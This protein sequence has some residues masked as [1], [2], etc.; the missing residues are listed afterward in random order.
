VA[1]LGFG[2]SRWNAERIRG[3]TECFQE[4]GLGVD[5]YDAHAPSAQAGEHACSAILLGPKRPQA[6]ICYNDLIALGF[7]KEARA[8]GFTLPDDVSV[9]GFDNVPYGE[10]ASPAL[11]TMDLQSERMGEVAM[12]KLLDLLA[13]HDGD[14]EYSLLEPRLIVR[15]STQRREA[16]AQAAP[17]PRRKA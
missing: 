15:E 4:A 13:G 16:G 14:G 8:L 3:V 1:Y 12:Q 7:M 2:Q 11:T 5:I 9:V 17:K 10:Y 6:V